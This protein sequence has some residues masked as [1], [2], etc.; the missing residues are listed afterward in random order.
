MQAS[1]GKAFINRILSH[2]HRVLA[3]IFL[4][5]FS[6][7]ALALPLLPLD[8]EGLDVIHSLAKPSLQHFF[9]TDEVGRDY[10][11]RVLYGGRVSLMVGFLSMA[12]SMGLGVMI[13]LL[14]GYF[15]GVVDFIF[16]RLVDVL[17]SIPWMILVMVFGM[18][19]GRGLLSLVMVIGLLSWMETARI[20]R[21]EVLSLKEREY[22]LYAR[23]LGIFPL[24]ILF[25]HIFPGILPTIIT[26]STA[27]IASSIMV[28]SALSFLGRGVTAPMSSWGSLL[29]NA[30]K[31]LQKAPHMAI[32][33]GILIIITVL[34]FHQWGEA[35]RE[36]L[37]LE[38]E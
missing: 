16:M 38:R 30:Q 21:G 33:P 34:S 9:G 8:P 20:I 32:L 7:L 13:G 14:S 15:G 3:S 11:A 1:R 27:A 28:E 19:F 18:V 23:F 36:S 24:R 2:P 22:V 6:L 10:F 5:V 12:M 37:L 4:I 31:F 35:L 25:S 17:S 26:A 29:Q